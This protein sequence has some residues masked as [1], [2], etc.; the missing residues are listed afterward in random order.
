MFLIFFFVSLFLFFFFK[1]KTA[2]E[3][4]RSLVGS[5]MCIRDRLNML[6]DEAH[7]PKSAL[8]HGLATL[9]NLCG[10]PDHMAECSSF[11]RFQDDWPETI[12]RV[13]MSGVMMYVGKLFGSHDPQIKAQ[14]GHALANV[15]R[16]EWYKNANTLVLLEDVLELS[17]IHI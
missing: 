13:L 10:A 8:L 14:A 11:I 7:V 5:E 9:S 1:Q 2:Y 17:L 6:Q 15:A 12:R 4:L 16:G 3:M